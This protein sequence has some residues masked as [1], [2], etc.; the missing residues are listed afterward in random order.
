MKST[1]SQMATGPGE[2][3]RHHQCEDDV[4]SVMDLDCV[5]VVDGAPVSERACVVVCDDD[6]ESVRARDDDG[7]CVTE[8]EG[9]SVVDSELEGI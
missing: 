7:V 9:E 1:A 4:V 8:L 6:S 5:R 3:E 2:G